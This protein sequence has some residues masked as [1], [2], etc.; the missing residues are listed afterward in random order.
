MFLPT[1][2]LGYDIPR[3][4]VRKLLEEAAEAAEL[5]EAFVHVIEL[6]DFSISYRVNG[7][8]EDV[9]KIISARSKLREMMLDKLHENDI[10]I[11]SPTF[12]NTRGLKDGRQF[13]PVERPLSTNDDD[14]VHTAEALVFDKADQAESLVNLRKSIVAL[15]EQI[16]LAGKKIDEV[17]YVGQ[18]EEIKAKIKWFEAR[19]D[20][21]KEMLAEKEKEQDEGK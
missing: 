3:R 2:S 18:Q 4:T 5:K 7:F 9:K 21:L 12:M 15:E 17:Q 6:G 13:I 20:R 14:A 8:L 16:E 19:R 1:F 11:V 10:E